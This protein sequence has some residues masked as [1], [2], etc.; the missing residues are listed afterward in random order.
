MTVLGQLK[1]RKELLAEMSALEVVCETLGVKIPHP[2]ETH[3]GNS[4][5][6]SGNSRGSESR[7]KLKHTAHGTD[8]EVTSTGSHGPEAQEGNA[9]APPPGAPTHPHLTNQHRLQST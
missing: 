1:R 9:A 7:L 3:K 4:G 2:P 8:S 6:D 5:V